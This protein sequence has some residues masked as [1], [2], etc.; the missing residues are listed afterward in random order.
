VSRPLLYSPNH[1]SFAPTREIRR[2]DAERDPISRKRGSSG[3][4]FDKTRPHL[5]GAGSHTDDDFEG[6][7]VTAQRPQ[8]PR[9]QVTVLRAIASFVTEVRARSTS[10]TRA[11]R[12]RPTTRCS[13]LARSCSSRG[14][15][16]EAD[17]PVGEVCPAPPKAGA[18]VESTND[19]TS[20]YSFRPL[21]TPMIQE[22][23]SRSAATVAARVD[24]D[25]RWLARRGSGR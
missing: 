17:A 12:S 19:R 23:D 18:V 13:R 11:R 9:G 20:I 10:S 16:A 21:P 25:Q 7:C 22:Q 8:V 15:D 24:I 4:R 2:R 6:G 14:R 1:A 5:P 3:D